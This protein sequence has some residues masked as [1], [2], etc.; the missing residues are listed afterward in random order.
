MSIAGSA[1]AEISASVSSGRGHQF[2]G[3]R[4]S[5]RVAPARGGNSF[6][7]AATVP[8]NPRMGTRRPRELY[9]SALAR[10]RTAI[11]RGTDVV[12]RLGSKSG[13]MDLTDPVDGPTTD[14]SD[15]DPCVAAPVGLRPLAVLIGPVNSRRSKLASPARTMHRWFAGPG[16]RSGGRGNE[17]LREVVRRRP[18]AGARTRT[19]RWVGSRIFFW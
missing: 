8:P 6:G 1:C 19:M 17:C 12:P 11:G 3:S 4:S 5:G 7:A 9:S 15:C 10:R 16:R 14:D 18:A 2:L 13:A